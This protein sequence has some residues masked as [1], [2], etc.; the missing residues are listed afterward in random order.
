MLWLALALPSLPL[1]IHARSMAT[2][3]PLAVAE[4]SANGRKLLLC[5]RRAGERGVRPGMTAASAWGICADLQILVRNSGAERKALEHIAA[6]SLQFTSKVSVAGP[7]ELL[8]E[9]GGSLHL[10][11][12]LDALLGRV[13]SG[14]DELGYGACCACAPT[15]LAA[16]WLVRSGTADRIVLQQQD[17]PRALDA[18]PVT[19][20]ELPVSAATAL[21][22][23]G[24]RTVGAC[25]KFPRDG[26]AHRI[27]P[28]LL[29][30]LDR[31]S[32]Q[33]ADPRPLY[34]APRKFIH[35]LTLPAPVMHAEALLFAARRLLSEL[36]GHLRALG[37]GAQRLEFTLQHERRQHTRFALELMAASRDADHLLTLL[38]ERLS[39]LELP[40]PAIA[41][42]LACTRNQPLD[43][44]SKT[45]L[46]DDH[47]QSEA[48][49]RLVEKLQAR[50]GRNAV[51]SLRLSADHRPECAWTS[52]TPEN[53]AAEPE[54]PGSGMRPLWLLAQPQ[55]LHEDGTVP[56]LEGPLTLLAGPE[57]IESGW[58]DG[59]PVARD[60]F[61][62]SNPAQ[63]VL[64]IYRE[65][66]A[67]ARW[68]LQGLFA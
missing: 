20:I 32:G 54:T 38:R 7:A 25:L 66:N 50:L 2:D 30:R 21:E 68:F 56:C 27:G 13:R 24:I 42:R 31:A 16:Q 15:P 67:G 58:W 34:M 46:P 17:I 35:T 47:L 63:A 4:E 26:L 57:R 45:M 9:I 59:Q 23:F 36:C 12:G 51:C 43:P 60:Y 22:R 1:E 18:L 65:R 29:D 61:V 44:A 11:D 48:A 62:A 64:W 19:V 8:L 49:T 53:D 10:F 39:N 40:Q 14:M 52:C 37:K 28:S 5:D 6:W 3:T 33:K 41:V 55:L